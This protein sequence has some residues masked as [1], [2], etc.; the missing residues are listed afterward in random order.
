MAE[1]SRSDFLPP[2]PHFATDAIHYAQ[3]PEQWNSRAV[4]PPITLTTSFKLKDPKDDQVSAATAGTPSGP[5][6]AAISSLRTL[7][8]PRPPSRALCSGKALPSSDGPG[9]AAGL[10]PGGLGRAEVG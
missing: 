2:F 5:A 3:E 1:Q 8:S 6:G 9:G 4:V 10:Q 7:P